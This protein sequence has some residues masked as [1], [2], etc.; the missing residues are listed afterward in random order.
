MG[1][2]SEK[3]FEGVIGP[4]GG[5]ELNEFEKL[6]CW[7]GGCEM[8]WECVCWTGAAGFAY[9]LVKNASSSFT[10][11]PDDASTSVSSAVSVAFSTGREGGPIEPGGGGA[12]GACFAIPFT[13]IALPFVD[14]CTGAK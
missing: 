12:L 6:V 3:L 8:D 11:I 14:N 9:P 5:M 13:C 1:V 10:S 4:T 2:C 7:R